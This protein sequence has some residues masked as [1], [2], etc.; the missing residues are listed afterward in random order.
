ML[1]AGGHTVVA[2]TDSD[3]ALAHVEVDPTVACVLTSLEVQPICG[4]SSAGR[5]ARLPIVAARSLSW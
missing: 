5:C 2:F 1:T 4:L 3:K